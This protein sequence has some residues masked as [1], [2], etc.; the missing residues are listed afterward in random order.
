LAT[1]VATTAA[2]AKIAPVERSKMPATMQIVTAQAMIPSG[3]D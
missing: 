1:F 2:T 3:A